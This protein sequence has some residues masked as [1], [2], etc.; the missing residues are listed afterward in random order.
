MRPDPLA[1][2]HIATRRTWHEI[3]R[4]VGKKSCVLLLHRETLVRIHQGVADRG[5]RRDP[6]LSLSGGESRGLGRHPPSHHGM[7]M[8]EIP[9]DDWRVVH[10]RLGS[11]ASRQRRRRRLR[12]RWRRRRWCLRRTTPIH[13]HRL[14]VWCRC[15]GRHRGRAWCSRRHRVRARHDWRSGGRATTGTGAALGAAGI[16]GSGAGVTEK[17]AGKGQTSK[18]G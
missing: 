6:R 12:C 18:G 16:T 9:M 3:P 11:R 2:H 17:P 13:L 8:S 10:R 14:S 1:S 15:R 7:N 4:L 5:F